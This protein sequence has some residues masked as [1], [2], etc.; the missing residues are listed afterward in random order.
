MSLVR[1]VRLRV[2]AG[3][4]RPG[5]A[6]GELFRNNLSSSCTSIFFSV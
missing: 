6:I 5:P 2:P 3:S 4:A 1:S